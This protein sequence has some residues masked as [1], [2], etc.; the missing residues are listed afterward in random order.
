MN[1]IYIYIYVCVCVCVSVCVSQNATKYKKT[2][3]REINICR[4]L[5]SWMSHEIYGSKD[6]NLTRNRTKQL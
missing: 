5:I 1:E 6:I 3:L 2:T 4:L